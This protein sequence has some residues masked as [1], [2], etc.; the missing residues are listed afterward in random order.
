M[1]ESSLRAI[2]RA[3]DAGKLRSFKETAKSATGL[4]PSAVLRCIQ[5]ARAMGLV[6]DV[7]KV[8]RIRDIGP[9]KHLRG[10]K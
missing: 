10:K 1:K 2:I 9:F 3:A 6:M 8:W 7:D 5:E 4:S